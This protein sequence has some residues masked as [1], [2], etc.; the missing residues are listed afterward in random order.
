VPGDET[1][2]DPRIRQQIKAKRDTYTA[3]RNQ[4]FVNFP[5]AT[6]PVQSASLRRVW[7]DVPAR[8]PGFTGREQMLGTMREAL[9]SGDR[10]V[11]QALRGMGGVGKT[12]L[13]IEYVHRHAPDYDI[14]WWIPAE[15]PELI[16]GHFAALATALG[17]T[18][19]EVGDDATVRRAIVG[20]L[21]GRER[22]LLVFD[23]ADNPG[24]IARWLPA[25]NGHVLI[26]S[27]ASG[28]DEVAV[29][30]EVDVLEREDSVTLL[31]RRIPGL[32]G[33]DADLIARTLGDLPLALAQAAAYM[34]QSGTSAVE[35]ARLVRTRAAEILE[36][37]RP[38]SYPLTLAAVTQLALERLAT[39]D[40]A[41]PQVVKICAFLGPEPIPAAWFTLAAGQMQEP[42]RVA[43]ADPLAWGQVLIQT[44]G[45][46]LIR[47]GQQDLLMHRLT[48]AII[49]TSL[50]LDEAAA[51][52]AQA[53]AL[54]T[55]AL[56]ELHTGDAVTLFR[57]AIMGMWT[58][59]PDD[60][61][62][63]KALFEVASHLLANR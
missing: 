33:K 63:R 20:A 23:N 58:Y 12:Q 1:G 30:V 53:N 50:T 35:Y 5:P 21:R 40:P 27:R 15:R 8:N 9:T 2:R 62:R 3:G 47:I 46:A 17:C 7:G 54:V 29:P 4:V 61:K 37:G 57:A 38:A 60:E 45:Q 48:R 13:A 36:C 43:A 39:A 19:Q 11:V 18:Q 31:R 49:R 44:N 10:A 22:W 28:W 16:V 14:V 24:D 34:H 6:E 52:R 55:A 26:T 25:G 41:A 56:L 42:L 32:G 51:A 59:L